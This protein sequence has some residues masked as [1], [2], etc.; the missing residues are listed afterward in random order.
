MLDVGNKHV[1]FVIDAE[2]VAQR[3]VCDPLDPR[4][5]LGVGERDV[6]QIIETDPEEG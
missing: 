1:A 5:E 6:A 3:L 4:R 2:P